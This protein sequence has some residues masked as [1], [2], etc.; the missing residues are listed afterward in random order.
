ML[1]TPKEAIQDEQSRSAISFF[2]NFICRN[3]NV[4]AYSRRRD[5]GDLHM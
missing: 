1:D 2:R 5:S 3:N 4:D